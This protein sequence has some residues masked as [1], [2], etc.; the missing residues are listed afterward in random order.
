[1][2]CGQRSHCP[3]PATALTTH[4]IS[5]S[6]TSLPCPGSLLA[7]KKTLTELV[8]GPSAKM[9]PRWLQAYARDP[10]AVVRDGSCLFE[11]G[12]AWV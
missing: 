1:M 2:H 12:G 4:H 6:S 5:S 10:T 9:M 8:K 3:S 11:V 7:K